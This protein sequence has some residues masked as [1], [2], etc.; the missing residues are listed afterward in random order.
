MSDVCS[1]T[2]PLLDAIDRYVEHR[3]PV[4]GFLEAVLTNNLRDAV[5]RA[6]HLNAPVLQE[7]VEHL[8]WC[9]PST[10]WGSPEKVSAWLN[11]EEG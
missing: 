5:G 7:Y 10:C 1:H 3:V 9:V 6:D 4:G 11:E 8:Y 2:L